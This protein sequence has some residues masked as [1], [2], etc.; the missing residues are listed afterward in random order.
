MSQLS[1]TAFDNEEVAELARDVDD[2]LR[3]L[4]ERRKVTMTAQYQLPLY[5]SLDGEPFAISAVRIRQRDNPESVVAHGQRVSF[6]WSESRRAARI[7]AIEGM[8]SG[9]TFYI[10]D[11]EVTV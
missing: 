4:A 5:L 8:S 7:D 3:A 9:A 1:T 11:F 2:Q 6:V 10:F